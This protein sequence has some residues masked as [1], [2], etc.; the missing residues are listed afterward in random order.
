MWGP[1]TPW[2]LFSCYICFGMDSFKHGNFKFRN[3][4]HNINTILLDTMYRHY[5]CVMFNDVTM[6]LFLFRDHL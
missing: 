1:K 3:L 6:I 4:I 2:S 5:V